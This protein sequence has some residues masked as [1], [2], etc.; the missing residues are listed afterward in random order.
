MG[1]GESTPRQTGPMLL[2]DEQW[3]FFGNYTNRNFRYTSPYVYVG[4]QSDG[5]YVV[6]G[7]YTWNTFRIL[8][9][10]FTSIINKV[11]EHGDEATKINY[12]KGLLVTYL[13]Y[14]LPN[15]PPTGSI[16]KLIDQVVELKLVLEAKNNL[17]SDPDTQA[18]TI[19]YYHKT[20]LLFSPID[21]KYLAI[22]GGVSKNIAGSDYL[23]DIIKRFLE[24][25]IREQFARDS[26]LRGNE[27]DEKFF[28]SICVKVIEDK[29]LNMYG[30]NETPITTITKEAY[31][32]NELK[33][34]G[35]FDNVDS[36]KGAC[37]F[38]LFIVR[39]KKCSKYI[40]Q[41]T[42]EAPNEDEYRTCRIVGVEAINKPQSV[43]DYE[44]EAKEGFENFDGNRSVSES[45]NQSTSESVNQSTSGGDKTS[46]SNL[47]KIEKF[48][49]N[50]IFKKIETNLKLVL[51]Y[52]LIIII[53]G[54]LIYISP[55]VFNLLYSLI[56][57]YI[58]PSLLAILG[59]LG[60]TLMVMTKL[61]SASM[62]ALFALIGTISEGT[63]SILS[64]IFSVISDLVMVFIRF[65]ADGAS[66]A[67]HY[68]IDQLSTVFKIIT[69]GGQSILELIYNLFSSLAEKIFNYMKKYYMTINNIEGE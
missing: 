13:P 18:R 64:S 1:S 17:D 34:V 40:M 54:V 37:K 26:L 47:Q 21:N 57:N 28:L 24:G 5:R 53:I 46:K 4:G 7:G 22:I 31:D 49:E 9:W 16:R 44:K 48:K 11:P 29:P 52:T 33:G 69:E 58:I 3:K 63:I 42:R 67:V 30:D 51:G 20:K 45:V 15:V 60:E 39:K 43:L 23:S 2:I 41:N 12:W 56:A 61:V 32:D 25:K 65:G 19:D 36:L 55:A 59:V 10:S 6:R 38:F 50:N 66:G 35:I 14:M 27:T 8:E 68:V 62:E